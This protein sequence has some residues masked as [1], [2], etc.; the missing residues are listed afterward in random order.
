MPKQINLYPSILS[1]GEEMLQNQAPVKPA[2][3]FDHFG[4]FSY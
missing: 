3:L 2:K 1:Y 4:R